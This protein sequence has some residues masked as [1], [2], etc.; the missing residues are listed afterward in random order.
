MEIFARNELLSLKDFKITVPTQR[1]IMCLY[2]Q[3][4]LQIASKI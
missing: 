2:V 3:L 4:L 1:L